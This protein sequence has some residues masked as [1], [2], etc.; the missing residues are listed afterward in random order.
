MAPRQAGAEGVDD[1]HKGHEREPFVHHVLT[2]DRE[3]TNGSRSRERACVDGRR[4]T[5]HVDREQSTG[6][7]VASKAWDLRRW[8]PSAKLLTAM[9]SS[10]MD[11][12]REATSVSVKCAQPKRGGDELMAQ[13]IED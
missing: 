8:V 12:V 2:V 7:R 6:R 3:V 4:W 11:P 10:Q 13:M 1:G 9:S 5:R